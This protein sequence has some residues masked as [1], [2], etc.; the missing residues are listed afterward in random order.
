[1]VSRIE[2][3]LDWCPIVAE[4]PGGLPPGAYSHEEREQAAGEVIAAFWPRSR[5]GQRLFWHSGFGKLLAIA[6]YETPE[7]ATD[8][9]TKSGGSE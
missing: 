9:D 1:M 4:I 3:F 7:L 6:A 8:F 5:V 2:R